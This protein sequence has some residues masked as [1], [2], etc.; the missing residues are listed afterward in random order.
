MVD[1]IGKAYMVPLF[2]YSIGNRNGLLL[3]RNLL[4]VSQVQMRW[5]INHWLL[6]TV[7]CSVEVVCI[8]VALLFIVVLP[9][10]RWYRGNGHKGRE[11]MVLVCNWD[12]P[13]AWEGS[14][15]LCSGNMMLASRSVQSC[16]EQCSDQQ[17][18]I[19]GQRILANLLV[20]GRWS[21]IME[22]MM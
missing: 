15:C 3:L 4:F 18:S 11:T 6:R 8:H 19:I 9:S 14:L 17:T 20:C 12:M 21:L 5:H 1:S 7:H 16:I 13:I 2:A 22:Y 10:D